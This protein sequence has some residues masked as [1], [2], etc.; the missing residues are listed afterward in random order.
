M[1]TSI[2]TV[3]SNSYINIIFLIVY[4]AMWTFNMKFD[5]GLFTLLYVLLNYTRQCCVTF[6]NMA[7]RDV[8]NY[9]TAQRRIQVRSQRSPQSKQ[10][11]TSVVGLSLTR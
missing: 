4:G 3:L 6:F 8:F 10:S 7:I 1:C 9:V 11:F 2:E 5:T